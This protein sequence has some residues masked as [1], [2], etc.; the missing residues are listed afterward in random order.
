MEQLEVSKPYLD[1]ETFTPYVNITYRTRLALD[2]E[3]WIALRCQGHGETVESLMACRFRNLLEEK[4]KELKLGP[5]AERTVCS[6]KKL[7]EEEIE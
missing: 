2:P 1:Y 6:D 4:L 3:I 7:A 5:Y